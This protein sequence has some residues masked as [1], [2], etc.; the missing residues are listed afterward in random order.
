MPKEELD[1]RQ[2]NNPSFFNAGFRQ[3]PQL[4]SEQIFDVEAIENMFNWKV[5]WTDLVPVNRFG[6]PMWPCYAGVDLAGRGRAGSVI[7]T[8]AYRPSDGRRVVLSVRKGTWG[9]GPKMAA[10]LY[11]EWTQFGHEAIGI[12]DNAA[13]A[14]LIE[15]L[16]TNYGV[17]FP[18]V[19]LTTGTNKWDSEIGIS[20][21]AGD[22]NRGLW[23]VPMGDIATHK[24]RRANCPCGRCAFY[25]DLMAYPGGTQDITLASWQANR[26]V[27]SIRLP[28]APVPIPKEI[29]NRLKAR[30]A[31]A[32]SSGE[33]AF[34]SQMA[35]D[36]PAFSRG[37]RIFG[38]KRTPRIF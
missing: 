32:A 10:E 30:R 5:S 16:H 8:V 35:P 36:M 25:R 34:L 13:Q 19:G 7:I 21:L 14:A 27:M 17:D 26:L 9:F 24:R 23:I 11:S 4:D 33:L 20:R 37:E 3:R 38:G 28:E 15:W 1:T 22:I 2:A 18:A 6:R 31:T 29:L 12:E